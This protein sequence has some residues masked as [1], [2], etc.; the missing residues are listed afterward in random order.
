MGFGGKV[1]KKVQMWSMLM[2]QDYYDVYIRL[3]GGQQNIF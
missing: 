3:K 2:T 1:R